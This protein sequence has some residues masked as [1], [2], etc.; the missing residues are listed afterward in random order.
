MK[1][2]VTYK[3]NQCE[4]SFCCKEIKEKHI[5]ISHKNVKLFCHYFNNVKVCP[6]EDKCKF[7]HEESENCKF[8]KSCERLKCMFMH[9][10]SE[11]ENDTE[12]DENLENESL[13][14]ETEQS[15]AEITF[16]NPRQFQDESL[17][18]VIP[19][20]FIILLTKL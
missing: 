15:E 7:L 12:K 3:C 9:D 2:H 17:S 6:S 18:K 5:K 1:N 16:S 4:K 20:L 8:S 11:D 10:N 19:K 14:D 13:N